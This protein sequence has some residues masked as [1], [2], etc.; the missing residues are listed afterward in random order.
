MAVRVSIPHAPG[1][2]ES[3]L[4]SAAVDYREDNGL[5]LVRGEDRKELALYNRGCWNSASIIGDEKRSE[6][7]DI[8]NRD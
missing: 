3:R 7:G 6:Y 4:H 5:L 2:A 8:V 1:E